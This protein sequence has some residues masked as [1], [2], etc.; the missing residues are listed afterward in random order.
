M[1]T[2]D[3]KRTQAS[4]RRQLCGCLPAGVLAG[5]IWG[6]GRRID[7]ATS[8]LSARDLRN[9][10]GPVPALVSQIAAAISS[11][12][13]RVSSI[14]AAPIQP[15]TCFGVRAPTMAPLTPG[16]ERV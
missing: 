2:V 11:R 1:Y 5:S 3:A 8:R 6:G 4:W 7:H 14:A 10:L 12:S 13:R 15:S 9:L 16:H